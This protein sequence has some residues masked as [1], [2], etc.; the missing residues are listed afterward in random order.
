MVL[1]YIKICEAPLRTISLNYRSISDG[2]Y[3]TNNLSE[4]VWLFSFL[5]VG[6]NKNDTSH[7]WYSSFSFNNM[8][9]VSLN[10]S[11]KYPWCQLPSCVFSSLEKRQPSH[12][13]LSFWLSRAV[14]VP[15]IRD[16]KGSFT[17]EEKMTQYLT[18]SFFIKCYM[19]IH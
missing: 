17:M 13:L 12:F 11:V 5:K 3:A 1:T 2:K 7:F 19:V 8:S 9:V 15:L 4:E 16:D 14:S 18:V 10:Y 6:N